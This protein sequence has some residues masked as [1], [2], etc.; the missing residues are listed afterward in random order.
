MKRKTVFRIAATLTLLFAS[1]FV[2]P[3]PGECQLAG[4]QPHNLNMSERSHVLKSLERIFPE[5]MGFRVHA[6]ME[7]V[8]GTCEDMTRLVSAF[9][10]IVPENV[11]VGEAARRFTAGDS[12]FIRYIE[13]EKDTDFLPVLPVGYA[14]VPVTAKLDKKIFDVHFLT[15]NMDRWLIWARTCYFPVWK[16]DR[17]TAIQEYA[18]EVSQYLRR[19]DFGDNKPPELDPSKVGAPQKS[20]LFG[21]Y[22]SERQ[23]VAE[24]QQFVSANMEMDIDPVEGVM[25]FTAAPG[26]VEW[27]IDHRGKEPFE[28]MNQG[29]LQRTFYNFVM[30]GRNFQELKTL[31][32][33]VLATLDPGIYF[34]AVDRY[35]RVRV[36]SMRLDPRKGQEGLWEERLKSYECLLFPGQDV[37]AA[38]E[39]EVV[40]EGQALQASLKETAVPTHRISAV[41]AFSSYYFY[42][43]DDKNLEKQIQR[44]S[45]DY[46]RTVGHFLKALEGMGI[47]PV[48]VHVSK[49]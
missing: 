47:E 12:P 31:T 48:G 30:D 40:S 39:F 1:A 3:S 15:V 21:G 49:F 17:D 13:I 18:A 33:E 14:G 27:M 20:D 10:V 46:L 11:T 28:D 2:L 4:T 24:Y 19:T 45:D 6:P 16:G 25:S 42:R 36:C 29:D 34:Y 23:G 35:G 7:P 22:K 37:A 26:A 44:R 41:N 5:S 43:S 9:R 32:P 8:G 38:G